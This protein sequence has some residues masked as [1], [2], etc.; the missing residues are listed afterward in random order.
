MMMGSLSKILPLLEPEQ[1]ITVTQQFFFSQP[2]TLKLMAHIETVH[3]PKQIS[4]KS[5]YEE[6]EIILDE[7]ESVQWY[8]PGIEIS[9]VE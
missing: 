6:P 2:G 5:K 8:Q 1:T 9:I 7:V 3:S 4:T